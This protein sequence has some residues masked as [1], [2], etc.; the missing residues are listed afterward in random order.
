MIL[1][2]KKDK[3][4]FQQTVDKEDYKIFPTLPQMRT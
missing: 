1:V 3:F 4:T 2:L